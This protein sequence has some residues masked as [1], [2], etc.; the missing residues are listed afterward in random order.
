MNFRKHK[1]LIIGGGIGMVLLMVALAFLYRSAPAYRTQNKA[2]DRQYRRLAELNTRN[3]FPSVENVEQLEKNLSRLDQHNHALADVLGRDPFPPDV[4]ESAGFSAMAQSVI[5]RFRRRAD[6]A[7]THLPERLE[8]GFA[9]YASGG[10]VPAAEHVPRLSRQLYSVERV[11]DVLVDCGVTSID[12]LTR[13]DFE[14][15]MTAA[16]SR[17]RRGADPLPAVEE[18]GRSEASVVGPNDLYYAERIGVEFVATEAKTWLVLE[19]LASVPHFMVVTEFS[20][21]TQTEILS[22]NPDEFSDA[23]D[24]ELQNF[25]ESGILTGDQAILRDERIVA[26]NEILNVSLSVWVYNFRRLGEFSAQ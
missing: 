7:G 14:K 19:R 18:E 15:P 16:P 1:V 13:E 23:A 26:G 11:A 21:I 20:Q 3:P 25:L 17:R 22:H 5:E 12:M 9:Q 2:I 10:V 4:I 24:A 6:E 8:A